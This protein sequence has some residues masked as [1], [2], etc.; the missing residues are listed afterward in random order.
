MGRIVLG[1]LLLA[2]AASG[3]AETV[4]TP[5]RPQP[6][7][8]ALDS[9]P[10]LPDARSSVAFSAT[11]W[12]HPGRAWVVRAHASG[13][14]SGALEIVR[15]RRRSDCNLWAAEARWQAPLR[16]A[17]YRA[18]VEAAAPLGTPPADAFAHD[19]PVRDAEGHALDGTQIELRLKRSGWE[20]RRELN[21]YGRG[22]AAI[23]ALFR[24]LV[25]KHVPAAEVPAEDWRTRRPG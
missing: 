13:R 18:L 12:E 23:S 21:H 16:A 11:P 6:I 3:R 4:P 5:C 19:D 7:P 25:A 24:A 17:E 8:P 2:L 20:A 22:G 14:G 15:L 1:F 9:V 10:A